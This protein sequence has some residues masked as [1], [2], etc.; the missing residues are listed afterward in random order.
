MHQAPE[1]TRLQLDLREETWTVPG[2]TATPWTTGGTLHAGGP[3]SHAP[4]PDC[5]CPVD[6]VRDHENE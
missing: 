4:Q 1:P 2:L 3:S 6:C 5:T